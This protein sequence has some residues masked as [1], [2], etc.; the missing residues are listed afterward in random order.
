MTLY[1]ESVM[2]RESIEGLNIQPNGTYVDATF[3]GGGHSKAILEC[4]G[5]QGQ[6]FAF[7]QDEDAANNVLDDPR[8][9]FIPQNFRHIQ[10]FLRLEGVTKIDGIIADLGVSW[11]QINTPQRG[12][13]TR[14][15]QEMLD[16]RMNQDASLTARH[17]LALYPKPELTR[18][19]N[20][21]GELTNAS[22]IAAAIV[23]VRKFQ[24]IQTVGQLKAVT[25]SFIYGKPQQFYARI[26]Q[27]FRIEANEEMEA[28]KELL[29]QSKDL[30]NDEGRVVILSYHSIEDRI[31]KNYFK[32]GNFEGIDEKDVFGHAYYPFKPI[33]KKVMMASEEEVKQ[34]PKAR[35]A[36]LRVAERS[37]QQNE[38]K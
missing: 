1:H 25:S 3:G 13:S 36:K 9:V 37:L 35:S 31:V 33:N 6:L 19:L 30:L 32:K 23:E 7:D 22:K 29:L 16:M 17:I 21:Y 2:L 38:Q 27:A 11:H 12:F 10:R 15:D 8:F 26:F 4:L 34:N 20:D 28:L 5:N 14:F 18:V 24:A